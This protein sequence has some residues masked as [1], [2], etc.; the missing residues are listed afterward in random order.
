MLIALRSLLPT[1][2]GMCISLACSQLPG[3]IHEPPHRSLP[4]FPTTSTS[5]ENTY[6]KIRRDPVLIS[7]V[8]VIPAARGTSRPFAAITCA[9]GRSRVSNT[10]S[11]IDFAAGAS[12][13]RSPP[14]AAS[15]AAALAASAGIAS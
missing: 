6:S 12:A 10:R 14:L 15:A 8:T 5:G 1:L 13:V 9:F 7:T 11:A 4:A 3:A 2:A